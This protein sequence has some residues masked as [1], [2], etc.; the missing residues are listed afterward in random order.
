MIGLFAGGLTAGIIGAIAI[1]LI[2]KAIEKKQITYNVGQQIEKGNEVLNTQSL[3]IELNSEKL[4]NTKK[5]N[6]SS[7]IAKRHEL[8]KREMEQSLNSIFNEDTLNS[9][10]NKDSFDEMEQMIKELLE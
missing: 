3:L 7:S 9:K 1:N 10:D 8:A 2:D 5:K 6:V 4:A